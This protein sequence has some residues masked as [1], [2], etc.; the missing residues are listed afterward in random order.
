M[1]QEFCNWI[2]LVVGVV[3]VE[4]IKLCL[5]LCQTE[6]CLRVSRGNISI[7]V[8][9]S[10]SFFVICTVG[11]NALHPCLLKALTRTLKNFSSS[12]FLYLLHSLP[13]ILFFCP[14]ILLLAFI[15]QWECSQNM[16]FKLKCKQRNEPL[17]CVF[18]NVTTQEY[19]M[20]KT[21]R[22]ATTRFSTRMKNVLNKNHT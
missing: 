18:K 12:D 1:A 16:S 2:V 6:E 20:K 19:T 14:I 21:D 9:P 15:Q 11:D 22:R 3:A 8:H 13:F 7:H 10:L 4:G 5:R 17:L